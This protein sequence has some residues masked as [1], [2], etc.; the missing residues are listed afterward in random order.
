MSIL[1]EFLLTDRVK[2]LGYRILDPADEISDDT[3]RVA[4][5][6]VEPTQAAGSNGD[7]RQPDAAESTV[8]AFHTD[9]DPDDP[10]YHDNSSCAYG[11]QIV[12]NGNNTPGRDG[13]RRCDWAG[14]GCRKS[15]RERGERG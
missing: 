8:A 15:S 9:T 11:Q 13:R 3:N 7:A 4:V 1:D 14:R 10:V 5:S 6:A 2:L 12:R